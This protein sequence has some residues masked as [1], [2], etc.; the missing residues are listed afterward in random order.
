MKDAAKLPGITMTGQWKPCAGCSTAKARRFTVLKTLNH[1]ADEPLVGYFAISQE[2]DE[3]PKRDVHRVKNLKTPARRDMASPPDKEEKNPKIVQSGG[4]TG[5]FKRIEFGKVV[6]NL[7]QQRTQ[8]SVL[9]EPMVTPPRQP[10]QEESPEMPGP[11]EEDD[12]Q[13]PLT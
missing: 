4:N 3:A 2:R 10:E 7:A 5:E 6:M 13:T 12:Q 1:R 9:N 11:P 8:R